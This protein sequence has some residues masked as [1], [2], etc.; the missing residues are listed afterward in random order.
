MKKEQSKTTSGR[1]NFL[2]K[3]TTGAAAMTIA[4]ITAP[5]QKAEAKITEWNSGGDD[6]WFNNIRGKHRIVFDATQPHEIFPFA[7]P[8]VFLAS[9]E[10][11]GTAAKDC[12]V[13]VVLR[14]TA[15]GYAMQNSMW[16]KYNLGELFKADDPKTKKPST[17]N[18]FWQPEKGDYK[19]PGVGELAIGIN[20]LQANGVMICVC[21][22]A[23][24]VF[25]GVLGEK[26]KMEPAEVKKDFLA[27]LL[28]GIHVVPSG[29]WAV[30][31]AQ[32]HGC[33]Y[34]FAG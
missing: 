21:D 4:G 8:R 5:F 27:N 17:R 15:I 3:I 7:W 26:M 13:V 14:H 12:S 6:E 34:C 19:L 16:T 31:R 18:P 33:S 9:N 30:G 20:E 10:K 32:E 1:R 24:T 25:S 23:M 2:G 22:T 11:T 29:V 28:P